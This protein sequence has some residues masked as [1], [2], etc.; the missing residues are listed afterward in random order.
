MPLAQ[1]AAAHALQEQNT[2]E[3]QGTLTGKIVVTP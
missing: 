3:K 1:A 2:L